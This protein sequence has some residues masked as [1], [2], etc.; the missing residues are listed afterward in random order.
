[1]WLEKDQCLDIIRAA[2]IRGGS[3]RGVTGLKPKLDEF[4]RA[5][6]DWSNKEFKNNLLQINKVKLR[7]RRIESHPMG[8][9]K[10]EKERALKSRLHPLRKSEEIY[11]R[12]RSRVKWLTY[13]DRNSKF[14]H[15]TTLLRRRHNKILRLKG[16]DGEWIKGRADIIREIQGFYTSLFSSDRYR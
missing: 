5:H 7:L 2:W 3:T 9:N 16:S 12:Q 1:M 6:T 15:Q 8:D 11:Y 14:F 4:K 13:G 10:Q